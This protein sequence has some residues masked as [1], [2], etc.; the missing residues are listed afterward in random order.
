MKRIAYLLLIVAMTAIY[1][2]CQTS[3][4]CCHHHT[5]C[6]SAVYDEV[7]MPEPA[8][9]P[10]PPE[11][12]TARRTLSDDDSWYYDALENDLA[13]PPSPAFDQEA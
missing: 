7:P 1:S 3:Q 6:P 2:G 12:E 8:D 13:L 5:C 9:E 10:E 4:C 11:A